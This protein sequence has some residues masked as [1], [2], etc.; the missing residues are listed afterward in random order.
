MSVHQAVSATVHHVAR[1]CERPGCSDRAEVAYG[2][3][4]EHLVVWLDAFNVAHGARSGV[5]CRRHANAMVVPLNW[6]LDDRREPEPQL[7]RTPPAPVVAESPPAR[8]R[9]AAPSVAVEQLRLDAVEVVSAV[10]ADSAPA[11]AVAAP[12]PTVAAPAPDA[13]QLPVEPWMP[14]FDQND[15]LTGLLNARGRLLSRAF[16]GSASPNDD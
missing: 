10:D 1:L 16:T 9:R 15:D 4:A 3:D 6:M 7:F 5:L 14:Q 8:R 11:P 13:E 2:F 12:A